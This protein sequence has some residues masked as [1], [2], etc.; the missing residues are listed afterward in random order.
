MTPMDFLISLI[1]LLIVFLYREEI[2]VTVNG[3]LDAKYQ[4][5]SQWIT[6]FLIFLFIIVTI[7]GMLIEQD[8]PFGAMTVGG[9]VENIQP[10]DS[11]KPHR[12]FDI[13]FDVFDF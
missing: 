8:T 4:I 2:T 5:K 1:V 6:Y 12:L 3:K 13:N 11:N 7:V 10:S 9:G